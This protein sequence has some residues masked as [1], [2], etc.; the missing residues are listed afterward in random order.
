MRDA[1][2][3][4][5]GCTRGARGCDLDHITP[6]VPTEAG[7]PP[8]QTHPDNL[9]AL[10]RRHHRLETL[11]RWTHHRDPAPPDHLPSYTWTDPHGRG[12]RVTRDTTVLLP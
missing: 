5:P 2:C 7:G 11:G 3:V 1:H 12:C 4:F 10:C 9:A 6:Y 8:G